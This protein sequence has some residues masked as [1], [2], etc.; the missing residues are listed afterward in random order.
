MSSFQAVGDILVIGLYH[1]RYDGSMVVFWEVIPGEPNALSGSSSGFSYQ[2]LTYLRIERSK[3]HMHFPY[4]G[5]ADPVYVGTR[6][7][8]MTR[9]GDSHYLVAVA[10]DDACSTLDFYVS[11]LPELHDKNCRFQFRGSWH[12]KQDGSFTTLSDNDA[13]FAP[14]KSINLVSQTHENAHS[15]FNEGVVFLFGMHTHTLVPG[16][17]LGGRNFADLWAVVYDFNKAVVKLTK[18]SKKRIKTKNTAFSN[19][20]G[21]FIDG[22]T[23]RLHAIY[24]IKEKPSNDGSI[25]FEE[26]ADYKKPGK[27]GKS[28]K[29]K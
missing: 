12:A 10:R 1:P 25:A 14:Y 5:G 27:S 24:S 2:E 28:G 22:K 8:G 3:Q 29:F 23:L 11:S 18:I 15:T 19:G 6:C 17:K 20:A 26:F 21:I 4:C 13:Y 9:L 7:V 16:V